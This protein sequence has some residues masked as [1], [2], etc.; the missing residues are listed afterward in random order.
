MAT[1]AFKKLLDRKADADWAVVPATTREIDA[2][3][4]H[5]RRLVSRRAMMAAGV[6]IVPLP[7]ID[8][9][10]D[11]AVL[12]RLI[13]DINH[14][15]GL[16]PQQIERLAP[17]RRVV[18]YKAIS[19]AGGVLIGKLGERRPDRQRPG[20][21][22]RRPPDDA[23][24]SEVRADRRPGGLGG[25]HVFVAALRLRAAHPAVRRDLAPTAA[26]G[27]DPGRRIALRR[28]S[29]SLARTIALVRGVAQPG[30]ATGLGPVG[31]EFESRRPDQP[32]RA[33]CP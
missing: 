9:L 20:A 28:G 23:A 15:F 19:A 6:S 21:R 10:T 31:R 27:A 12:M 33:R 7:G 16:T 1:F 22:G 26:A 32:C 3:V 25:A 17:D 8:W 18:V 14:A 13:P 11:I 2:V 24:G 4:R 5:C 30:S 29:A